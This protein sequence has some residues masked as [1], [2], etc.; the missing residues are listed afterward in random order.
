MPAILRVITCRLSKGDNAARIL[1]LLRHTI[2]RN[3]ADVHVLL[4]CALPDAIGRQMPEDVPLLR[5]LQ[6]GVMS[7]NAHANCRFDLLVPH[8]AWSTAARAYIGCENTSSLCR[9]ARDLLT[10]GKAGVP[11]AAATISP[12]SVK[13]LPDGAAAVLFSDLSLSCTPDTP[14]R[15]LDALE[16]GGGSCIRG[17][18]LHKR[19][20]P[21]SVLSRLCAAGFSLAPQGVPAPDDYPLL[22]S[23]AALDTVFSPDMPP[24][25]IAQGCIFVRRDPPSLAA[26]LTSFHR[27]CLFRPGLFSFLPCIQ[28]LSL[29]VSAIWGIPA[30]AAA[31][32]LLPEY[33]TLR[34]L[35]RL[36]GVLAHIALLPALSAISLDALLMRM[37][38]HTRFRM[39]IPNSVMRPAGSAAL[40]ALLFA[41]AL[42]GAHALA[43]LLPIS[44]LWL[45]APYILPALDRPT[46]ARIPLLPEELSIIRASAGSA[47]FSV[48]M[49]DPEPDIV[50]LR[51][52]CEIAG[53]MLRL[54]ELDE[55]ARR[56]QALLAQ[57]QA[58]ESP[59]PSAASQAAMLA[60]AQYLRE[61]MGS[62]DAA[63]RPLPADLESCVLSSPMPQEESRLGMFLYAAR[64]QDSSVFH[65]QPSP[66][67]HAAPLDALF[68]PLSPARDTPPHAMTLALTHPHPFIRLL[69]TDDADQK[70][71]ET[72]VS[73][74][75]FLAAAA[76]ALA[77]PFYDLL[78][79]SPVTAPY[80]ALLF[81]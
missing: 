21:Q 27:D 9:I 34:R 46:I 19:E 76:A 39:R 38:A 75:R 64:T 22:V 6:S 29:F 4:I 37:T 72:A 47:Y 65:T 70:Q 13:E 52:L 81:S 73:P 77:H 31:A 10:G 62:C 44:V 32:L 48:G 42:R 43:P 58:Q 33:H 55:A 17:R 56:A 24:A 5:A 79:R 78:L 60:S 3:D 8:R 18:V 7:L 25:P 74:G 23:S 49:R 20:Y 35:Q 11:F 80:S 71:E 36:P 53:C 14:G 61:H 51:I 2:A 67:R 41:A 15:M 54:I 69:E 12:S 26:L 30:L 1:R 40:G 57:Y 45:A 63:L 16:S 68:L 59:V 50:P 28:A 66:D